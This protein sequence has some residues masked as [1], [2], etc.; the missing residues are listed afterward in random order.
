V[1]FPD[2]NNIIITVAAKSWPI[3]P[4]AL[5]PTVQG[6]GFWVYESNTKLVCLLNQMY[7]GTLYLIIVH[8]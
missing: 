8:F 4:F 6:E 3:W 7:L 5:I 2:N 1:H